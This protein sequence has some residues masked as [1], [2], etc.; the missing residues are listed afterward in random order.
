MDKFDITRLKRNSSVIKNKFKNIKD[1]TVTTDD[2]LVMFPEK[3][4]SKKLCDIGADVRVIGI[5]AII[6]YYNNYS[7]VNAPIMQRLLPNN[8][9]DVEVNGKPYKLLSFDKDS[10]FLATNKLVVADNFVYN[11]FEDLFLNGNIPWYLNYKDVVNMFAESKKYANSNIGNDLMAFE[12]LTSIISRSQ[13]DKKVY[14]RQTLD[15]VKEDTMPAYVG[16]ND[17]YYSYDNTGAKILGN[18]F[19]EGLISAIVDKEKE[20]SATAEVLRS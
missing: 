18:Y 6:D 12:I 19:G 10:V 2:I 9:S 17:I 16:P 1:I 8:I 11:L 14:Y 13:S 4:I 3:F 7:I 15:K 5:Y 20:T